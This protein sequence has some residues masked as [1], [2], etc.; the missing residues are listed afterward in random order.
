MSWLTRPTAE[1]AIG[2]QC[3]SDLDCGAEPVVGGEAGAPGTAG[4]AGNTDPGT[5]GAPPAALIACISG[6]CV[7]SGNTCAE[8]QRCSPDGSCD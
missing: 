5:G 8:G 7:C 6:S 2:C 1:P 3:D 4:A